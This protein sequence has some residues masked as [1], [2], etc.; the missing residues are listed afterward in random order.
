M[1][2]KP[3]KSVSEVACCI[4]YSII[5]CFDAFIGVVSYLSKLKC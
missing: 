3:L 5:N 2:R 4:N 1:D